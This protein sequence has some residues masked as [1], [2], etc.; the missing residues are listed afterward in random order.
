MRPSTLAAGYQDCYL[1]LASIAQQR[2]DRKQAL[3]WVEE[4][5]SRCQLPAAAAGAAGARAAAERRAHANAT[6]TKG[7]LPS[8]KRQ[9]TLLSSCTLLVPDLGRCLS[10]S[11]T[12]VS[13][14]AVLSRMSCE[15]KDTSAGAQLLTQ[16]PNAAGTLLMEGGQL[17]EA[18]QLFL[19]M[20]TEHKQEAYPWLA[21]G[22]INLR[23]WHT[24][25][26]ARP[27]CLR[28]VSQLV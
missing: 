12:A 18:E 1:R 10:C 25:Y 23:N 4:A 17:Q 27:L 9:A 16:L 2:G 28:R 11:L 5:L 26:K 3:H 7:V 8:F 20:T 21:L 24:Y 22:I 15:G 13:L 19:G 14:L 6:A